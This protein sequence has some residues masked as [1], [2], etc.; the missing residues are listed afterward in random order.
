MPT[1]YH[2]QTPS[3][4]AMSNVSNN[5]IAATDTVAATTAAGA[6]AM[7]TKTENAFG[8]V[9][10]TLAGIDAVT[11]AIANGHKPAVPTQQQ[12]PS[13]KDEQK[14]QTANKFN[15]NNMAPLSTFA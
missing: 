6:P 9:S 11:A 13:P 15:T 2:E 8:N 14:D 1:E 5:N 7:Q 12:H 10:S 3:D 4:V